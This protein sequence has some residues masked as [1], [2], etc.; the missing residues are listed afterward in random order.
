LGDLEL[1]DFQLRILCVELRLCIINVDCRLAPEHQFPTGLEDC[2]AA[3]KWTVDNAAKFQ[4]SFAKGF[5]VGGSSAGSN[6]AT[7][8][9]HRARYDPFFENH[10]ITGHVLQIPV[11]VHPPG[12]PADRYAAELLSYEQNKDTPIVNKAAMTFFYGAHGP[13]NLPASLTDKS[14][15]TRMPPRPTDH[16]DLP[17]LLADHSNLSV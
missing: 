1:D 11:L 13:F 12:Y 9:V 7:A 10:K 3:L 6:L 16:P 8:V 2:Y 4:A 14:Y 5:I 15:I 17:P